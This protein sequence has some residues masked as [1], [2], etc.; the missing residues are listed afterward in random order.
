MRKRNW[1]SILVFVIFLLAMAAPAAAN[2]LEG[3]IGDLD[4]IELTKSDNLLGEKISVRVT[5]SPAEGGTVS[6]GGN[7]KP[8]PF[9]LFT[10]KITVKASPN[11]G[12]KFVRWEEKRQN[13]L[14]NTYY[15]TVSY[16]PEYTFTGKNQPFKSPDYDL[17]A[18]FEAV[19]SGDNG[20]DN[21]DDNGGDNG[22]DNGDDN[23]QDVDPEDP[24]T[25]PGDDD[26]GKTPDDDK[27]SDT[28]PEKPGTSPGPGTNLPRTDGGSLAALGMALLL[29]G[30]AA[31]LRRR[32]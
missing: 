6:G 25:E 22:D 11:E 23:G 1:V 8:N 18:I 3:L 28:P 4:G 29:G 24:G 9:K 30:G 12:Y 31:I 17:V 20:G 14:G 10:A 21:G 13:L 19:P 7:Y 16:E 32:W 2:P 5:A 26:P 27:T 15:R